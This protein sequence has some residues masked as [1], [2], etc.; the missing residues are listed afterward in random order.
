M[1]KYYAVIKG[2]FGSDVYD[3]WDQCEAAVSGFSGARHRSFKTP[4]NAWNWIC[5]SAEMNQ[6]AADASMQAAV[7]SDLSESASDDDK[8]ADGE[9]DVQQPPPNDTRTNPVEL[10]SQQLQVVEMCD[11]G[12]SVFVTGSAGTG[13]SVL[14]RHIIQRLRYRYDTAVAVTAST[15]IAAINVGGQTL[16]SWAGIGLG[17][18]SVLK[19]FEKLQHKKWVRERWL[20]ARVL[21]IDEVSMIDAR[22]F[23]KLEELARLMRQS[24][25]PF[26]GIQVI[27]CGDFFQL[28]P[29][30]DSL[31]NGQKIPAKFAFEAD[32]WDRV[33]PNMMVLT[34][35]FRQ[36]EG[37]LIAM[38]NMMRLGQLDHLGVAI[39]NSLHRTIA[40]DDGIQPTE[41]FPLRAQVETANTA[42]LNALPGELMTFFAT[43][44]PGYDLHKKAVPAERASKLLD[45]TLA[46]RELK[47]KVGAQV[48]LTKNMADKSLV[49]GSLGTIVSFESTYDA[50]SHDVPVAQPDDKTQDIDSVR[51][52]VEPGSPQSRRTHSRNNSSSVHRED[53]RES[54]RPALP[55]WPVVKFTNGEVR[56]ITAASFESVNAIGGVEATRQQVPLILAWA[57]SIHKS[58]GQTIERVK[59]NLEG[60]FEKGQAYVAVSRATSLEGLQV[61]NFHPDRIMAHPRVIAW[62]QTIE[63]M[64]DTIPVEEEVGSDEEMYWD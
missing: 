32:S 55:R 47:L 1:K 3:S 22:L 5:A 59:V 29:V 6:A 7:A 27:I 39:F 2:R 45:D 37:D 50:R 34:Q 42:R 53:A 40:Y 60:I 14:L 33:I 17:K 30:P 58:Q 21:I 13:K 46:P 4:E 25:K 62:S 28:P 12:E 23:D 11:N 35:V 18:E 10:S 26:G 56:Q 51:I 64:H 20:G 61:V 31:S 52:K 41:L 36:K 9:E 63:E 49:N 24:P 44:I 16:H 48:M 19:L 43:D 54:P 38:L 8:L 15:G 57:M